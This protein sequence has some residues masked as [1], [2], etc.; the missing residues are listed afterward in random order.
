MSGTVGPALP[1][2]SLRLEAVPEMNY[3]PAAA[4]PRGEVCIAGPSLFC[5]YYKDEA[6]TAEARARPAAPRVR[7]LL[8]VYGAVCACLMLRS[9]RATMLVV[10]QGWG[11]GAARLKGQNER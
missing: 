6:K 3:A 5:G 10:F 11:T 4:P 1:C 2:V 9:V 8:R 7:A